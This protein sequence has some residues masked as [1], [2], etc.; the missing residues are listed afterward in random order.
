MQILC[1]HLSISK[2]FFSL[3]TKKSDIQLHKQQGS[4][5]GRRGIHTTLDA[6]PGISQ[7]CIIHLSGPLPVRGSRALGTRGAHQGA[8]HGKKSCTPTAA[9]RQTSLLLQVLVRTSVAL[10]LPETRASGRSAHSPSFEPPEEYLELGSSELTRAGAGVFHSAARGA[11]LGQGVLA[12]GRRRQ[13]HISDSGEGSRPPEGVVAAPAAPDPAISSDFPSRL[14][15]H[16]RTYTHSCHLG[17]LAGEGTQ[18]RVLPGVV[19]K[20][21]WVS[22]ASSGCSPALAKKAVGM[23]LP[24]FPSRRR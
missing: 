1:W 13:S 12:R 11:A 5:T 19:Q 4:P 22:D 3:K 23:M 8:A 14:K 16:P 10:T 9:H 18:A 6:C 17:M 24:N 20:D 7:L 15:G 21:A 2:I